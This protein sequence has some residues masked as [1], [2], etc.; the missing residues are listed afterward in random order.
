[1]P[2]ELGI[3]G[4]SLS[5]LIEPFTFSNILD[6]SGGT[7]LGPYVADLTQRFV[8]G[9]RAWTPDGR[10]YKYS[11][12]GGTQ[13]PEFLSINKWKTISNA[14][15]PAGGTTAIGDKKVKVTVGSGEGKAANGLIG[16]DELI[17]GYAVVGNGTSQHSECRMIVGNSAVASGGGTMWVYLDGPLWQVATASTTNVEVMHNVY[18]DVVTASVDGS[19]SSAIGVPAVSVT[20]TYNFW[21]QTWGAVWLTSNG[22]TANSA[23]DREIYW[24]GATTGDGSVRSGGDITYTTYHPVGQRIGYSLD[25]SSSGAS[26]APWIMLQLSR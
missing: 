8:Y 6:S 13:Y 26:N 5:A 15:V 11:Y 20:S 25:A 14:V 23:G 21:L 9:Q 4:R 17:G 1:M 18:R 22:N 24:D 7:A 3:S 16:L 19:Y 2:T 12:A 10:V